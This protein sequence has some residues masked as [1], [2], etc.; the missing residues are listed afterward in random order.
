MPVYCMIHLVVQERSL[1]P[2]SRC[3][4]HFC[5]KAVMA[6]HCP[7]PISQAHAN[8]TLINSSQHRSTHRMTTSSGLPPCRAMFSSCVSRALRSATVPVPLPAA[9]LRSSSCFTSTALYLKLQ[10]CK[11]Q[12][13][14][15]HVRLRR[16]QL[17][18]Q[19]QV[20][21]CCC[22]PS[23]HAAEFERL[24]LTDQ[25]QLTAKG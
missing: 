6:P 16:E 18:V 17:V 22:Q 19:G 20:Q 23:S 21:H 1:G 9:R 24:L 5:M 11:S 15:G 3:C 7:P 14:S 13:R 4:P 25:A 2:F 10:T 8:T 12:V